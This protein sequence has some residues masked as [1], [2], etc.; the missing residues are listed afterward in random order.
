MLSALAT[1]LYELAMAAG[2]DAHGLD[3]PATFELYVRG[4]PPTRGFLIAAGLDQALAYLEGLRLTAGEIAYLRSLPQFGSVP[5][6]FFDTFLPAL[7]FTGDIWAVPEGTPVFPP[8]PLL[9]VTAPLA[10]AQIVETALLSILMFQTGVASKA[11]R[12]VEAAGGRSVIE[13]GSRRAHGMEAAV[14]AARAAFIAGC[15]A[16]SNVEAGYRF[17]IPLSGTMAHAWVTGF[18]S[19]A[20]AFRKYAESFGRRAVLLLDTYDTVAAARLIVA[21]G[22]Q[23]SAVRLDSGDLGALAREVRRIFD[24]GGLGGTKILASGELDE[25]RIADL[26]AA[27]APIDGFGVGAAISTGGDV[28]TLGGVYKLVEVERDGRAVGVAKLSEGKQTWPCRK[29][30]WRCFDDREAPAGSP[31]TRRAI[32]DVIGLEDEAAPDGGVPL[33]ERVMAGGR[34]TGPA[35]D[36][37]SLRD[38]SRRLVDQ[39]PAGVRALTGFDAYPVDLTARLQ[40]A[41]RDVAARAARR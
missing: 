20:E 34:R 18:P 8:A 30:V 7:R 27:G 37:R 22:L 17:G 6:S 11:A 16:T 3:R 23:P 25:Y 29:Q 28:P 39:L 40:A 21:E 5:A 9:R 24:A 4:L 19:E 26:V 36:V 35:P 33:L 15:E 32:R 31:P 13:F 1:D 14:V 2:Y 12:V 38:R 41:G 10:Q